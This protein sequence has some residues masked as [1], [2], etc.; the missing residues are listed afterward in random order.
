MTIDCTDDI[1]FTG[2]NFDA[3]LQVSDQ[4]NATTLV[5]RDFG[6]ASEDIA[7]LSDITAADEVNMTTDNTVAVFD[8]GSGSLID[9]SITDDGT[10]VQVN[11][12]NLQVNDGTSDVFT[13]VEEDLMI[14]VP[15][16]TTVESL[17]GGLVPAPS[18]MMMV[19]D[20]DM[21]EKTTGAVLATDMVKVTSG[22]QRAS[23]TYAI[24][25]ITSVYNPS[26]DQLKVYPNPAVNELNLVL[27]SENTLVAVYSSVGKKMEEVLVSG[28]EHKFNISNY[29]S[30]I[31]FVKAG[32]AIGKFVK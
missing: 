4:T 14:S 9:G 5:V 29:A 3:T 25:V 26:M 13:V 16:N 31:Y 21:N 12:A 8:L 18:A 15:E 22:D 28:T 6:T 32:N 27:S 23:S 11:S 30:G 17:V 24:T 19:Y 2:A 7:M 20:V 1:V 10:D